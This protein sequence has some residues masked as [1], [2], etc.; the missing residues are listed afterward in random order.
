MLEGA[1]RAQGMDLSGESERQMFIGES[2]GGMP[3][4]YLAFRFGGRWRERVA[5]EF[6]MFNIPHKKA[7]RQTSL[8]GISFLSSFI[9]AFG[10]RS[11]FLG[12]RHLLM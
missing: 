5:T 7:N 2:L 6:A 10:A 3:S 8:W 4:L 1:K 9:I 12:P 11:A